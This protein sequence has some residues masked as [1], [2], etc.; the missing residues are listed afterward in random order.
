NVLFSIAPLLI[1]LTAFGGL[2]VQQTNAELDNPVQPV[3]TWLEEHLPDEAYAF[4]EIPIESALSTD[5]SY[6]LSIGG[7]LALWAAKNAVASIMRGLSATYGLR[8]DRPFLAHNAV[9]LLLT[10]CTAIGIVIA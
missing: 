1:C 9:A 10:L 5:P 2:V 7:I 6:L 4:L 3:L 8:H